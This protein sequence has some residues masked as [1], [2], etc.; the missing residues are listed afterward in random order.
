[1]ILTV[2]FEVTLNKGIDGV[3][4]VTGQEI[5]DALGE[6]FLD[7]FVQEVIAVD[8]SGERFLLGCRTT[9]PYEDAI[10]VVGNEGEIMEIDMKASYQ[11]IFVRNWTFSDHNPN[12]FKNY[13]SKVVISIQRLRDKLYVKLNE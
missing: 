5:A 1:M 7:Y 3:R 13:K 6:I 2:K 4:S 10:V 8:D 12:E 11:K 9:H